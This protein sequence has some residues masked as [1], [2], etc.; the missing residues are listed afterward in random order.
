MSLV[1]AC[2]TTPMAFLTAFCAF[3]QS[4][5]ITFALPFVGL[6]RVESIL[7]SVV[8][9]APLGPRRPKV[10]PSAIVNETS[11]RAARV[12]YFLMRLEICTEI[13]IIKAYCRGCSLNSPKRSAGRA[14]NPMS[15][16]I[17]NEAYQKNVIKSLSNICRLD[18]IDS[19]LNTYLKR[20]EALYDKGA[21]HLPEQ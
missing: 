8:L 9:P 5:P 15:N 6:I 3:M 1:I 21:N 7:I 11:L 10:S 2:G 20:I 14:S 13:G 12:P 16:V 4:K 18:A 19:V 17:V